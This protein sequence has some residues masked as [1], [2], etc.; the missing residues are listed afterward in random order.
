MA[1]DRGV[2]ASRESSRILWAIGRRD[3]GNRFFSVD[4]R[5]SQPGV[6][7]Q[8]GAQEGGSWSKGSSFEAEGI[9]GVSDLGSVLIAMQAAVRAASSAPSAGDGNICCSGGRLDFLSDI[10]STKS[11]PAHDPLARPTML[12]GH[13]L[14]PVPRATLA[15]RERWAH[16][17]A[18]PTCWGPRPRK[19][20]VRCR[21]SG[22]L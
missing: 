9:R 2:A 10:L 4:K 15:D 16:V 5:F 19:G 11:Y 17:R 6:V 14:E 3:F 21:R 1:L 12:G 7:A 22:R 13:V 8:S 20:S 18:H